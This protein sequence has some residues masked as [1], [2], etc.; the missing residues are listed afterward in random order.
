MKFKLNETLDPDIWEKNDSIINESIRTNI[1]KIVQDFYNDSK[2]KVPIQ[3]IQLVG[4]CANYNWTPSSDMDVHILINLNDLNIE[5]EK[6]EEYI[7]LL[8]E[9]WNKS[10]NIYIKD[11]ILELYIQDTNHQTVSSGIYSLLKNQWIS[12]PS[13]VN[14]KIE[15][16]LIQKKYTNWVRKTNTVIKT[17]NLSQLKQLI[18]DVIQM[19][20]IGLSRNGEYSNENLLFKLLRKNG[21]IEKI[22]NSIKKLY[23]DSVSIQEESSIISEETVKIDNVNGI[24]EVPWNRNV[25]YRGF[26]K[27]F[28]PDEFLSLVLPLH[29]HNKDNISS[30]VDRIRKE[31]MASPFLEVSWDRQSKQ[32]KI[33]S[34]E[35][36]HRMLAAK[37]INP[38]QKIEVHIFPDGGMR[39]RDITDEMKNAPMVKEKPN[40]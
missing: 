26:I 33:W 14:F 11:H 5:K 30:Y 4:S 20:N 6:V 12:V 21:I 8:K 27:Y 32:W 7:W 2:L 13:K 29:P 36:R 22:K 18:K 24:G 16:D 19:R 38:N 15:N 17:K 34:H 9:N 39:A 3:D 23:D 1:L 40:R 10:H 25:S 31:G 28:T 35:G 37:E